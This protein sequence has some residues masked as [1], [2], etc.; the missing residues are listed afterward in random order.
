MIGNLI[1]GATFLTRNAIGNNTPG[2]YNHTAIYCGRGRVVEAQTHVHNGRITSDRT[3]P[4]GVILTDLEEF[5]NRY[6]IISILRLEKQE[7]L[8]NSLEYYALSLV[9]MNYRRFSS[10]TRRLR[11]P[12]RGA[13]CVYV[14]RYA[15]AEA[16]GR[17]PRW[18]LP[19]NI[20]QSQFLPTTSLFKTKLIYQKT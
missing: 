4:G 19:D 8:N 18:R 14:V 16:L 9:G 15:Y 13:N 6:P 3:K 20:W 12:G 17:D 7:H 10:I 1:E 2:Y 5:E 11:R